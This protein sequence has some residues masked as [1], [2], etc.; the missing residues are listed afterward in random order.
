VT[1]EHTNRLVMPF[2]VV[3]SAGGPYHDDSFVAGF[4]LSTI[5]AELTMCSHLPSGVKAVPG[6]RYI[7]R[8]CVEQLDLLAMRHGYTTSS[9][10]EGTG[11]WLWVAFALGEAVEAS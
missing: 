10:D 9:D 8:E 4:N 6:P 5:D 3:Q 7:R 1:E 2:T 11:D